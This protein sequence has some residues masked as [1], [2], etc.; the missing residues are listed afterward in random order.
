MGFWAVR[1]VIALAFNAITLWVASVLPG[2]RLGGGFWWAVLVFTAVSL[3]TLNLPGLLLNGA[4][5]RPRNRPAW[6]V[7]GAADLAGALAGLWLSTT[8]PGGLTL[9]SAMAWI[10][11]A[12]VMWGAIVIQDF[13]DDG[14]EARAARLLGITV[15]DARRRLR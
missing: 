2:F 12:A 3:L 4:A 11:A 6:P 8:V 1:V 14:L 13:V 7:R 15:P 9:S 5:S 10:V